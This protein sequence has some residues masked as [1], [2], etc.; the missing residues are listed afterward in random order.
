MCIYLMYICICIC[1]YKI[2]IDFENFIS[3]FVTL[4]LRICFVFFEIEIDRNSCSFFE[5]DT[6]IS[7]EN[8]LAPR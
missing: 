5:I 7:F 2:D 1:I 3:F 8:F 4:I 6:D